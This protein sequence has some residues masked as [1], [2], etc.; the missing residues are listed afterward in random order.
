M[1][2]D[3]GTVGSVNDCHVFREEH[4]DIDSRRRNIPRCVPVIHSPP[5]FSSISVSSIL[6]CVKMQTLTN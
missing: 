3:L 5:V 2:D 1:T 6:K 4:V